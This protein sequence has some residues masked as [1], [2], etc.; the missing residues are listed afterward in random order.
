[1]ASS[2]PLCMETL[3]GVLI[4]LT[5]VAMLALE[6]LFPAQPLPRVRGWLLKGILFF[7]LGG[8]FASLL[9]ALVTSLLGEHAPFNLS[10]LGTVVGG[11]VGFVAA[12][13]VSYAVH[14][15]FHNV[16]FLWRWAHQMHHSAE[17]LDVAGSAY[18]HPLDNLLQ[19]GVNTFVLL[20]LG[21]SPSAAGLAGYVGFFVATFQHLNVHTPKLMRCTTRAASTPIIMATS[22]S[23]TSCSG[24]SATRRGSADRQAF[25][26]ARRAKSVQC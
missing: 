17:R 14:R 8:A 12:D 9:P 11:L 20:S 18:F 26:M 7:V 5:F 10:G 24:P 6:R 1:M 13:L 15:L 16:P 21:L 22:C 23:G 25:G 3:L 2:R 19:G 4:P